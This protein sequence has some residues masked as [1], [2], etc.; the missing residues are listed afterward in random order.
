M[1]IIFD[2]HRTRISARIMHSRFGW[3]QVGGHWSVGLGFAVIQGHRRIKE[4]THAN[5]T[6]EVRQ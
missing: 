4:A 2:G 1:R 5:R 6:L 3:H